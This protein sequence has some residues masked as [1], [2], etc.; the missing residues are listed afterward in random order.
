MIR[1]IRITTYL[2]V[3]LLSTINNTANAQQTRC[4]KELIVVSG[5]QKQKK[6]FGTGIKIPCA[7]AS[8]SI[9]NVGMEI[10]SIIKNKHT[11]EIEEISFKILSNNIEGAILGIEIYNIDSLFTKALPYTIKKSIPIGRNQKIAIIPERQIILPQGE[12]FIAVRFINCNKAAYITDD[13][14]T[15]NRGQI[16]FPLYIKNSYIRKNEYSNIEECRVNLGLRIKGIEY[17]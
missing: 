11:F 16:L 6:M 3:L 12:F 10:G 4:L 14:D 1:N 8:L 13:N 17:R 15:T 7:A 2:L 5:K 9:N